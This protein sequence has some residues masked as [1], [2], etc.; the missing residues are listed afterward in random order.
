MLDYAELDGRIVLKEATISS[1][2]GAAGGHEDAR[3]TIE[4]RS[5]DGS[6]TCYWRSTRCHSIQVDL[7]HFLPY[8]LIDRRNVGPRDRERSWHNA[9]L[10][11]FAEPLDDLKALL[12]RFSYLGSMRTAPPSL[13]KPVTVPPEEVGASGEYAAQMLHARRGDRV[14]YIPPLIISDEGVEAP[15]VVRSVN[16]VDAVN[17]VLRALSIDTSLR[18]EDIKDVGFRLLFGQASLL[19][20]GRG[21][22]GTPLAEY[23]KA[24]PQYTHCAFEEG[25]AHL[26]PKVQTRLAHLGPRR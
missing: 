23:Q 12:S 5:S 25:E 9:F 17:D 19:H 6:Y 18:I 16:L 10:L 13:Y 22:E 4:R 3:F 7:D 2:D 8:L 14:H 11:C 26:H 20:V 1:Y 21:Q 24:C 15:S